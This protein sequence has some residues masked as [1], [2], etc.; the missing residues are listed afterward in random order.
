MSAPL[1]SPRLCCNCHE[2][3]RHVTR[4]GHERGYCKVCEREFTPRRT[5]RLAELTPDQR[6]LV[7]ALIEANKA[8][9]ADQ[10]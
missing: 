8:Q 2:R 1:A 5:V 10:K 6:R 7:L 4:T 3:P 9:G